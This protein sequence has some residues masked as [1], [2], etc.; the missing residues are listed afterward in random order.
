[1]CKSIIQISHIYIYIS[2]YGPRHTTS[3][4]PA[5]AAACSFDGS[6]PDPSPWPGSPGDGAQLAGTTG[7]RWET[8]GKPWET[9]G[10]KMG[11]YVIKQY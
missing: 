8:Y 9:M 3:I 4:P 10:K 1:M 11:N 2:I 7:K 6:P 5:P